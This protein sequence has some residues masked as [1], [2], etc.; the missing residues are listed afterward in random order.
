M[1]ALCESLNGSNSDSSEHLCHTTAVDIACRD[2]V[3]RD[4]LAQTLARRVQSADTLA[5]SWQSLS[6]SVGRAFDLKP[7][8]ESLRPYMPLAPCWR[9]ASAPV[10]VVWG[11]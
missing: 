2:D 1:V 11:C 9:F 8:P 10:W 3:E 4:G 6:R 5:D 7:P